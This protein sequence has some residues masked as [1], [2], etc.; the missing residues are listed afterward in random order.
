MSSNTNSTIHPQFHLNITCVGLHLLK[1]S[2]NPH[3]TF[4]INDDLT[5]LLQRIYK[6]LFGLLVYV[7]FLFSFYLLL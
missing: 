2:L 4:K 7:I 5:E 3:V 1:R 6:V